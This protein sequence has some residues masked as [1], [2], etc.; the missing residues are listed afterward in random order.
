MESLSSILNRPEYVHAAINHFPLVGLLVGMLSLFL[1]VLSRSR[2]AAMIGLALVCVLSLSVWFV[3][4]TG[5]QG[6]DRVLSMTDDPGAAF[7][8]HHK[9]LANRWVFLYF[10]TGGVA[11]I[12]FGLSWKWPHALVISSVLSLVLAAASLAAG[13]VIAQAGGEIRH[14]EFRFGPPPEHHHDKGEGG[15]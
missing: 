9:E 3:Y 10:I 6:Y 12:G 5:E 4:Y 13:V 15:A 8:A 2:A 14:R 11:A 1:G 7:L